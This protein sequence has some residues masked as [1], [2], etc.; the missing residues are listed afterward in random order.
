MC[1][2]VCMFVYMCG[3]HY[4]DTHVGESSNKNDKNVENIKNKWMINDAYVNH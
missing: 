2:Y 1:I 4:I 3:V